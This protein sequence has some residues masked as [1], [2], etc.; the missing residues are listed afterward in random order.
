MNKAHSDRA[1]AIDH[2]KSAPGKNH[3]ALASHDM[4]HQMR[5]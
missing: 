2:L 3:A 1:S 5:P 4:Q